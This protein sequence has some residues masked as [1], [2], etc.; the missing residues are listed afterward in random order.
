MLTT[1]FESVVHF[2]RD[3]ASEVALLVIFAICSHGNM[4]NRTPPTHGSKGKGGEG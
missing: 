4:E 1:G 2:S 3:L